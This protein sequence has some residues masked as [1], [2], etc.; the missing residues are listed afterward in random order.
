MSNKPNPKA[1]AP[2]YAAG[3]PTPP[4]PRSKTPYIVGAIL[5]AV[6][7]IAVVVVIVVSGGDGGTNAGTVEVSGSP[8]PAL[9]DSMQSGEDVDPAVGAPAPVITGADYDGKDV[10]IDPAAEGPT[11]VV[12]LAHWCPH[13][14][15]EIPVLNEWR[16]SGDVPEGLNVVGLSTGV[17]PGREHYPPGEWLTSMDWQWPVLADDGDETAMQ[18]LGATTFPTMLFFGGDGSLRWRVSGEQPRETIQ[19]MVDDA[20]ALET[21]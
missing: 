13:C 21:S 19:A 20:M 18:A 8:L 15:N 4:T 3:R 5:A 16:D 7:V 11:L 9:T 1:A 14:N 6:V 12:V 2:R 17:T 10:T